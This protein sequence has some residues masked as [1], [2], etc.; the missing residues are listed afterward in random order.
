MMTER[1]NPIRVEMPTTPQET[2]PHHDLELFTGLV[3]VH[4][5]DGYKESGLQMI[6]EWSDQRLGYWHPVTSRINFHGKYGLLIHDALAS[7]AKSVEEVSGKIWG[8]GSLFAEKALRTMWSQWLIVDRQKT[9]QV[10]LK[11]IMDTAEM[12]VETTESCNLS[13][14]GC[15]T[16][17]DVILTQEART[18]SQ[19]MAELY[20]RSFIRSSAEKGFSQ[21]DIKWAGGES[22]LY[23]PFQVI[24]NAQM[25]IKQLQIEYPT[26]KIKQTILTN[27]ILIND[28]IIKFARENDVHISV[29]LWGIG[30]VQESA[31][32]PKGRVASYLPVINNIQHL[33]ESGVSYNVSHVVT[34]G[35]AFDFG[36]FL[37]TMW[38]T[39][40]PNFI[41][42]ESNRKTPVNL[43]INFFRSQTEQ[44]LE[45][46]KTE[47]YAK[48]V[49]GLRRGFAAIHSMIKRGVL[50]PPLNR[51]DYMDLLNPLMTPCGTGFNY[52]AVGPDGVASCH[53]KLYEMN[54]NVDMVKAGTNL[55]DLANADYKDEKNLLLGP[56]I[57][58]P[59]TAE[60]LKLHGA[61]G[62]P[63]STKVETHGNL[64]IAGSVTDQLYTQI[65]PEI[66]SLEAMRQL[67]VQS[68]L[69]GWQS[70]IIHN[71][72][73]S[74]NRRK[75][76]EVYYCRPDQPGNKAW[77]ELEEARRNV[78]FD[79]KTEKPYII[80]R[81]KKVN[82][83]PSNENDV[84]PSNTSDWKEGAFIGYR[85]CY[86][87][88]EP[89]EDKDILDEPA[90]GFETTSSFA[91]RME[92]WAEAVV[93]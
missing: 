7:G 14:R 92:N 67:E 54:N 49:D 1:I 40:S 88:F 65:F 85:I 32:R 78:F 62:C 8:L 21:A 86:L 45:Y 83:K 26:V 48:M 81:G 52:V 73:G 25:L 90:S 61:S 70:P 57:V 27:G 31:R 51:W 72:G 75:L 91:N 39:Q 6:P 5:L 60:A 79:E 28:D 46:M 69:E 12:Y 35:N 34:P 58:F 53:E 77:E 24:K 9:Q 41:F 80:L 47:G 59:K 43:G 11:S 22:L 4:V 19:E 29:S 13:C 15:A 63:I 23:K 66:L 71:L 18:L 64:G 84:M 38:D 76:I 68:R 44:E 16:K 20:I 30:Q 42:A 2:F 89:F 37:E 50:V 87:W 3:P 36:R 93:A 33:H 55:F 17:S 56:N 82:P 10:E 74:Y